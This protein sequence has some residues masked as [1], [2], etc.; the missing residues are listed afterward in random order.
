MSTF[1]NQIKI[2][3]PVSKGKPAKAGLV[4]R[5]YDQPYKSSSNINTARPS[6]NIAEHRRFIQAVLNLKKHM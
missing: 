3:F 5:I 4:R 1:K 6:I 2:G